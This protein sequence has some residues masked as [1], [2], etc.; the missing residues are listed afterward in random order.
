MIT[1]IFK[2]SR[3]TKGNLFFP[4]QIQVAEDG[5]HYTKRKLLG[6]TEENISYRAIAS[7][8][9]QIGVIFAE[10]T[11][12]TSGGVQPISINGLYKGDALEIKKAIQ[13]QQTIQNEAPKS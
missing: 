11:I 8:K 1:K 12:E 2:S 6:S 13:S 4:D 9:A 5:I 3:L 7:V 10:L